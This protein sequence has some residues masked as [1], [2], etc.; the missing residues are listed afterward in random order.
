MDHVGEHMTEESRDV[1]VTIRGTYYFAN[2]S[3]PLDAC[4]EEAFCLVSRREFGE[5]LR[6]MA[7]AILEG[8]VIESVSVKP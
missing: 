4:L 1:E 6:A 5:S 3:R 8:E 7:R 2:D